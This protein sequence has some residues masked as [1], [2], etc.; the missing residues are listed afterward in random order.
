LRSARKELEHIRSRSDA[1][2]TSLEEENEDVE[3]IPRTSEPLPSP[4]HRVITMSGSYRLPIPFTA[5]EPEIR[6]L[7]AGISS[8]QRLAQQF[9][10]ANPPCNSVSAERAFRSRT[11]VTRT[12]SSWSEWYGGYSMSLSRP[13][14]NSSESNFAS[15]FAPTSRKRPYQQSSPSTSQG[16]L[17]SP[18][19]RRAPPKLEIRSGKSSRSDQKASKSVHSVTQSSMAG[20]LA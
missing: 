20:L 19:P 7:Q 3:E 15:S 16:A 14:A 17:T 2:S 10:D 8:A 6:S 11:T 9:L 12:G 5:S 18:P 1:A 4:A 13:D